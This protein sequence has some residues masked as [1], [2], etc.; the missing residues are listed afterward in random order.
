MTEK[1]FTAEKAK[2]AQVLYVL[3]LS[4]HASQAD[5]VSKL[6]GCFAEEQADEQLIAAVNT[7]DFTKPSP[8]APVSSANIACS[9][10]MN[11]QT[12]AYGVN[13]LRMLLDMNLITE[14]E[15]EKITRISA[16]YYDTEV[17]CV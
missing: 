7:E 11:R 9:V 2:E 13:L 5:F 15:Y 6:V 12:S 8:C 4:D 1:G 14:G 17:V 16:E 10:R 3:A